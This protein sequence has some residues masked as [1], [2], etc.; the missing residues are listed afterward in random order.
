MQPSSKPITKSQ[1]LKTKIKVFNEL[2]APRKLSPAKQK[3]VDDSYKKW[4]KK[5]KT[6]LKK[7]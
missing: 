6:K 7:G 3:L 1:K 2:N 4:K 5:Q